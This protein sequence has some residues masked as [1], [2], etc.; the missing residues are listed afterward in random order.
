MA[1]TSELRLETARADQLRRGLASLCMFILSA[2][3]YK[4][5]LM[6]EAFMRR[7][8]LA[9]SRVCLLLIAEI[10]ASPTERFACPLLPSAVALPATQPMATRRR[11]LMHAPQT[12][13][14]KMLKVVRMLQMGGDGEAGDKELRRPQVGR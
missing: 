14:V 4:S 12:P 13:V 6:M 8:F 7:P 5:L 10:V 1:S 11:W 2:G 3:S 9:P